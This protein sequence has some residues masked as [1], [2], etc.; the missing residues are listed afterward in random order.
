MFFMLWHTLCLTLLLLY[1]IVW[2]FDRE[3]FLLRGGSSSVA[4][5]AHILKVVGSNPTPVTINIGEVWNK[6]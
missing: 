5:Q 6:L 3:R 2:A 1:S 4:R